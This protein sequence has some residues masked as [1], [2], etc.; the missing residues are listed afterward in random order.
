M[1]SQSSESTDFFVASVINAVE[2]SMRLCCGSDAAQL[3]FR[4]S[5]SWTGFRKMITVN[6]VFIQ[7]M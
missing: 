3:R 6:V 7:V 4:A 5:Y 2:K 1:N